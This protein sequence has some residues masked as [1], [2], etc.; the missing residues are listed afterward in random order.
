MVRT[1]IQRLIKSHTSTVWLFL[2]QVSTSKK[3]VKKSKKLAIFLILASK[4]NFMK[5]F[6]I[7]PLLAVSCLC[8]GFFYISST[9]EAFTENEGPRT[10]PGFFEYWKK[11]RINPTTG[12]FSLS[13]YYQAYSSYRA[14]VKNIANQKSLGLKWVD[15]GP[16]NI[17]GRTRAILVDRN[18]TKHM[19]AG[20]VSGGL[21]E[22]DDA[23]YT[24]HSWSNVDTMTNINISCLAQA[25]NGDIYFG[26]GEYTAAYPGYEFPG[27]GVFKSTDGGQSFQQIK[28]T[29]TSAVAQ[30]GN[31]AY[32]NAIA[33]D[34]TNSDKVYLATNTGF[35]V[36]DNATRNPK[37]AGTTFG[38]PN[39]IFFGRRS[40][41]ATSSNCWD[42]QCGTDG[43]VVAA[44]VGSLS[45][46]MVSTDGGLT[47]SA[48]SIKNGTTFQQIRIAVSPADPNYIYVATLSG[49]YSGGVYRSTDRGLTFTTIAPPSSGGSG[50]N[51]YGNQ[52]YYD[53]CIAAALNNK[54]KIF[55]GGMGDVFTWENNNTAWYKIGSGYSYGGNSKYYLHPDHHIIVV[56]PTNPDIIY[57]GNDG[58]IYQADNVQSNDLTF[59]SRNK[60]YSPTQFYGIGVSSFGEL[61][62]GAQDNGTSVNDFTGIDPKYWHG[63]IGGD[64]FQCAWSH[65]DRKLIFGSLYGD[66]NGGGTELYRS[67]NG[68]ISFSSSLSDAHIAPEPGYFLT[69]ISLQEKLGPNPI[70]R[71]FYATSNNVFV[72]NNPAGTAPVWYKLSNNSITNAYRM[73]CTPDVRHVFIGTENGDV[74]RV[75]NLDT[76]HYPPASYVS[77]NPTAAGL[78][79]T[80]IYSN[81][82]RFIT[83]IAVD[84]IHP[85]SIVISM[86]NYGSSNFAVRVANAVTSTGTSNSIVT[87]IQGNL[88]L[89]PIYDVAINPYQPN[90]CIAGTEYGIFTCNDI[91]AANPQWQEDNN[92][93]PRVPTMQLI[94]SPD[95]SGNYYL[96]AGTHGRGAFYTKTLCGNC[97]AIDI[98]NPNGTVDLLHPSTEG[99]QIYPNPSTD[100]FFVNTSSKVNVQ[101]YSMRGQLIGDYVAV[102]KQTPID[103]QSWSAGSYLVVIQ[104]DGKLSS[105]T[106]I[107]Q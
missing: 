52:G 44:Q 26:T 82:G 22:S 27:A 23:G 95:T 42:V 20:G 68:G 83:G 50:F 100:K 28:I 78:I 33:C 41:M 91:Y 7:L 81:P 46:V 96:F 4:Y 62:G 73:I 1:P 86:S 31:F 49:G 64:G 98:S 66:S 106:F 69:R 48:R 90:Q 80:K 105:K 54:D 39:G 30:G 53:M 18:N 51:P 12:T 25:P 5:R 36:S 2:L 70:S 94:V 75:S 65:A 17:G 40:N 107:K 32:I 63:V 56:H 14:F 97:P 13:D 102:T 89:F 77:F 67:L 57:V 76:A 71:L 101:V 16:H 24:W 93:F 58:G 55:I 29:K 60:G 35:Y 3:I 87:P 92:G 37:V 104:Q 9:K 99:I 72:C 59:H 43:S 103:C 45:S 21:F 84:P 8:L 79:T 11:M 19:F 85:D 34:P 61:I 15:M 47:F 6:Y 10:Y 74:F 88:P 38:D